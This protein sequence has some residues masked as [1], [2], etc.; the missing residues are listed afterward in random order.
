[1]PIERVDRRAIER[2]TRGGVHQGIAAEV[3]DPRDYTFAS[4]WSSGASGPPLLVVLDGIED[5]HNV[6]AILRSV[7]AAGAHG[8]MRQ[9]RHAAPL[10]GMP[11]RRRPARSRTCGLR[12]S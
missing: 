11:R 1:M 4:S 6:G 10:D 7:D 3:D 12:P 8:V 2:A 9:A 5:P